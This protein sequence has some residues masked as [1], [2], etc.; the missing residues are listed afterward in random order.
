MAHHHA[1]MSLLA[2]SFPGLLEPEKFHDMHNKLGYRWIYQPS[3]PCPNGQEG[4]RL[5]RGDKK[6]TGHHARS[7]ARDTIELTSRRR[8]DGKPDALPHR[9]RTTPAELRADGQLLTDGT[10]Y[11]L[12]GRVI[13]WL[14]SAV[15]PGAAYTV[16]YEAYA[17]DWMHAM[18]AQM[19]F[20]G[21]GRMA[22][23]AQNLKFAY[24][25]Q[26]HIAVSVPSYSRAYGM[27][28]GDRLIPADGEMTFTQ[29]LDTTSG[30]T[31]GRHRFVT[32]VVGAYG[33][34]KSGTQ[35]VSV[36]VAWDAQT[37]SFVMPPGELPE[38]VVVTYRA[39]PIYVAYLDQGEFRSPMSQAHSRLIVLSREEISR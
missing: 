9:W 36:P 20:A 34:N 1:G 17:E 30:D 33:L 7:I 21:G 12:D 35:E 22:E 23:R 8:Q 14:S 32:S 6:R 18:H 27:K 11:R 28:E 10:D 26:G 38:R 39:A 13:T 3:D 5:C 31:K 2:E 15:P 29:T 19:D 25:E 4:C 24:L 16:R 37:R